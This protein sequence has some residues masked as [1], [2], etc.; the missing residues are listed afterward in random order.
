MTDWTISAEAEKAQNEAAG[1][2]RSARLAMERGPYVAVDVGVV[3]IPSDD[4]NSRASEVYRRLG[5]RFDDIALAWHRSIAEPFKGRVY[6]PDA[7]LRAARKA[8]KEVWPKWEPKG[9]A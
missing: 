1:R 9:D 7:W 3:V 5:M 6:S 4:Y 2:R 8:Y